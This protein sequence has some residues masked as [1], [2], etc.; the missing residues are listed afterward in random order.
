MDVVITYVNGADPEW[1][2]QYASISGRE[3][4][5]RFRDWGL[6]PFQIRNIRRYLPFVGNIYLV[7][8]LPSQVP[9]GIPDDVKIVLHKDIIPQRYLPTFNSSTIELYLH[10]IEGLDNRFI[11][12]NDDTIPVMPCEE[13]DFFDGDCIRR[14]FARHLIPSDKFLKLVKLTDSMARKAA[15]IRPGLFFV[16]PQHTASPMFKDA[17][18]ELFSKVGTEIESTIT[19]VRSASNISQYIYPDYLF[20]TGRVKLERLSNRHISLAAVT[21][22]ALEAFLLNPNRKWVCINDVELSEKKCEEFRRVIAKTIE[23]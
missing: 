19:P 13:K 21:P 2:K 8:A 20:Y 15:G 3:P 14:G 11:Y 22:R 18:E 1:Q 9:A 23:E 5:K 10:R 17:C 16:R 4:A 12:L 6:L 7:V